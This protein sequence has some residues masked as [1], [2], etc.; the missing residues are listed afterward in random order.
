MSSTFLELSNRVLKGFNEVPLTQ[1]TFP[2]AVGFHADVKD[3]VNQAVFDIYTFQDTEWPFAWDD[4]TT[5]TV[6]GQTAYTKDASYVAIDWQS[7]KIL[8][9]SATAFTLTQTGGT[10]TFTS[11]ANHNFVTG[12]SIT[13]SGANETAYNVREA[14][15]TVTG[16][17]TFTYSVDS[18]AA[19]S[20]TGTIVAKSNTVVQR[21]LRFKDLDSYRDEKY[22][23]SDAA[24][25][26]D[27]Y[28]KP[29]KVIR[30]SDNNFL[31]SP[32]PDRVYSIYY[33]GFVAPTAMT[34]Y[35]DTCTIPTMFDQVIVDKA[36]HFAYMFRDNLEQAGMAQQRYEDNVRKMRR[37]LIPQAEYFRYTD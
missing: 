33:E 32:P 1:S 19:A 37:I 3:A 16:A 9:G 28:A 34:L 26:T 13:I 30:K 5:T 25:N 10:A 12:D 23:D 29:D 35:N 22:D 18:S 11:T 14:S 7:F 2:S 4:T 6:V 15:I 20:A 24:M 27:G 21:T 36:L 17:T 8:R 31:I